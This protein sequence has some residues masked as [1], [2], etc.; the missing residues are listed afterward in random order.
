MCASKTSEVSI[1]RIR[2]KEAI[3]RGKNRIVAHSK[4]VAIKTGM[5]ILFYEIRRKNVSVA[6]AAPV[7]LLHKTFSSQL[8]AIADRSF[9]KHTA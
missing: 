7:E 4:E 6:Y 5:A 1:D 8:V 9:T 2:Q 3:G